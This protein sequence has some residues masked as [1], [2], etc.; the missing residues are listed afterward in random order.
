M[1]RSGFA[2]LL[3]F[4]IAAAPSAKSPYAGQQTRQIKSLDAATLDA[5]QNG[6]GNGMAL[7]GELNH[8]PGPRHV[9]A[10]AA[11][12]DLTDAQKAQ[13]EDIYARM[14]AAAVPVGLQIIEKERQL[15]RAF[16]SGSISDGSLRNLTAQIAALNGQLRDIHL[17]AHL[18]TKRVLTA[19]QIEMYDSMRGYGG[20][21][22]SMQH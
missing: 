9:L 18:E 2:A 21:M 15:D 19:E 14:H 7:V 16:Q 5:L 13:T 17:T 11:H 1:K 8:Y 12:L 3:I 20:D 10:M 6:T 22:P 4:A